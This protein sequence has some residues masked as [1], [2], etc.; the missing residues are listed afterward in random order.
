MAKH[1]IRRIFLG[2]FIYSLVIFGIFFLQFRNQSNSVFNFG[3]IHVITTAIPDDIENKSNIYQITYKEILFNHD[4]NVKL[5]LIANNGNQ[6][7]VEFENW[8]KNSETEFTLNFSHNL[9]LT[10]SNNEKAIKPFAITAQIP[11]GYQGVLIPYKV[12]G[13]YPSSIEND[14]KIVISRQDSQFE[15]IA[16]NI[17]S[18]YNH[19]VW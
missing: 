3:E 19:K 8:T 2:I 18:Q 4:K 12:L 17:T 1:P 16:A 6:Q 10:F 7:E 5:Q 15:V 14:N 9:S 11:Q 13:S